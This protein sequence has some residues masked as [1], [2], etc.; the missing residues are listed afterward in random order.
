MRFYCVVAQKLAKIL[1]SLAPPDRSKKEAEAP[2]EKQEP[3]PEKTEEVLRISLES[4][5]TQRFLDAH[6]FHGFHTS[7]QV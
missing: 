5:L 7:E 3:T 2:K 1:I 6:F 4:A